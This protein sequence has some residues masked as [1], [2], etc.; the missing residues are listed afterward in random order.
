MTLVTIKQT[1]G[2]EGLMRN[3]RL[4]DLAKIS[5]PTRHKI[6]QIGDVVHSQSLGIVLKK[7]NL[8]QSSQAERGQNGAAV[9]RV[10]SLSGWGAQVRPCG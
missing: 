6:G 5:R 3:N 10:T 1:N 9:G 4:I 8:T 7:L 2:H